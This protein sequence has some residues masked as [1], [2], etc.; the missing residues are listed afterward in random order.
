MQ[1][2]SS[3]ISE[4]IKSRIQ[5]L[6]GSADIR[7][8]GTVISVADGICRIHGLSDVMQGEMLE[9]PGNTFGLAMNLERDSVGAV[10]LGAY[11]HIS[12]TLIRRAVVR[13]NYCNATGSEGRSGNS[14]W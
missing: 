7:N 6:E 4:L 11:E 12:G 13:Q 2:N 10:I 5:G 1:L 14:L 9:F 3:E 8:Q